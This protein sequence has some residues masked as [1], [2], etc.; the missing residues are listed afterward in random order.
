MCCP[1]DGFPTIRH[2]EV[3]DMVGQ[4]LAEV[5]HAVAIEPWLAPLFGEV[6][7]A[8]SANTAEDARAEVR[9][10]GFWTRAQGA[11][12]DF[13]I[14]HPDAASYSAQ[15]LDALLL[16]HEHQKKLEY[17]ER[18]LNMD[19][20]TFSPLAFLTSGVA[21]PECER[22]LERLCGLLFFHTCVLLSFIIKK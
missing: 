11:L 16:Q 22:F 5:C 9:A 14:F 4:L 21:S 3:R 19:P 13:R 8:A 17:V 7:A 20:G 1:R 12:F 6:F 15:P 18:I 2:N 10:R